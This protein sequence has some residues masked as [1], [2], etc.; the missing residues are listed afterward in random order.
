MKDIA[1]V[2]RNFA[3]RTSLDIGPV[4]FYQ[5]RE[6]PFSVC[7]LMYEKGLYR[8]LPESVAKSVSEGVYALHAHTAGGRVKFI[9]DSEFIAISAV[10]P[11]IEKMPHFALTGSAGFDLYVGDAEEY[12][13]SFIPPFDIKDGYESV[14]HFETRQLREITINFPLY[15]AV[16]DLRIGLHPEA[17]LQ[18]SAGYESSKPIVFYGSSITQG[19]CAS[20]PGNAYTSLVSR[21]LRRDH[22][23]LGFSGNAKGEDEIAQYIRN[24][25]MSVFVYDY[26]HNAPDI[27]HLEATHQK[28]FE[29]IRECNPDLPILIL[30][31]PKFILTAEE[32]QRLEIIRKTYL[33]AIAKGDRNVYLIEG[34]E[35]MEYAKN[36]G[37]VDNCHPNDLGFWSMAEVLIKYLKSILF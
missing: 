10:M 29:A 36:H 37:T 3:I 18:K 11:A 8:R 21:A 27:A 19:G 28:M 31:R 4:A 23:N 14:L 25:D 2:D 22:I 9:T 24:L 30:S 17:V 33:D 5:V 13:G 32:K 12:A 26:D 34:P 15:S 1:S 35:L 6:E 7:G 16:A 20:R